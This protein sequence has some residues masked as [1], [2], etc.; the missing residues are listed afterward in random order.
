M[1]KFKYYFFGIMDAKDKKAF[2]RYV[3]VLFLGSVFAVL[4]IG[5]VIPFINV[6]IQP[7]K[8]MSYQIFDGW[9]YNHIIIILTVVLIIAFAVKNLVAL[10]L[11]NYQSKFLFGLMA[12]IQ[13]KL[14]TGYMALPYEYHLNRSTPDL[15]KNVNNETTMLSNYVVAPFG[16]FLTEL[17]SS[18][19]VLVVLFWINPVFTI[20]VAIFLVLGV[21]L[22][23]RLIKVKIEHYSNVRSEA[24]SSMTEN[25]LAGLS[26][27]KESKL[28]HCEKTFLDAFKKDAVQLK[29][30]SAFQLTFQQAPRMLI[31]FIGLTVVMCVL[32]GF[33]L[34]GNTPQSMFVLLGVFGVA[35]AQLL[36]SLNRLTQA[37]VQIKYGMPAL[38]GIYNELHQ[39]KSNDLL[40]LEQKKKVNTFNFIDYL[41]LKDLY[42]SYADGT[43]AIKGVSLNI[44]KNKKI[45]FVGESGAGKTTLVD[46]VMGLYEPLQGHIELDDVVIKNADQKLAFQKLFAYI[47]Q[48]IVLYDKTIRENIAFG[49]DVD[50]IDNQRIQA[51]LQAAQLKEFVNQLDQKEYTFIGESG[52]RLSGGQRQRIG[53]A[54]ALYQEPQILVMDEATSALDN[55]TER[56]VTDVLSKLTNLTIITIAHRLS[57]I[58]DYDVIFVMQNGRVI[59]SGKYGE[60]LE[61][62][63]VFAKIAASSS[64]NFKRNE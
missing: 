54:R 51:C 11:L 8:V 6:L 33:V 49:V 42:Y 12:K 27:I 43:Q 61:N 40:L 21:T 14:F 38:E 2:W 36:P 60:L 64:K 45:A 10:W 17:L 28:Y 52:V 46:L 15:I 30:S 50:K 5:A 31:E 62:C 1:K 26:G 29:S 41:K 57:T 7:E 22:F 56:E 47:P 16:S 48:S 58:Q 53:I 18:I 63:S 13:G 44:P 3:M 37:M 39:V 19:F 9:G 4:G 32:C 24:W 35:A 25:V 23:M 20:L 55:N 34:V 59:S